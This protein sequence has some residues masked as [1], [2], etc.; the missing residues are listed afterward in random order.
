[1]AVG[2]I[3]PALPARLLA[4]LHCL[5]ACPTCPALLQVPERIDYIWSN[6]PCSSAQ[7]ALQRVPDATTALSYSDHFAVQ[8]VLQQ[9]KQQQQSAASPG[10]GGPMRLLRSP[11]KQRQQQQQDSSSSSGEGA[12]MPLQ[13]R[14]ATL[15]ASQ[16]LLDEGMRCFAASSSMLSMLGGFLLASVGYA[17][18]ALPL[19]LPD[20]VLRGWLMSVG[21]AAAGLVAALGL[22][23][24]LIGQVRGC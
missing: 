13:Q 1:L 22:L 2:F 9:P 14:V 8:A 21:L 5:P 23:L 12:A 17:A 15:M 6:G 7:V 19:L 24:L 3:I 11:S 20:V 4:C 16:M 18:V 10:K